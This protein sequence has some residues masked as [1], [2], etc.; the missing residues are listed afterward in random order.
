MTKLF[1]NGDSHT[2]RVWGDAGPTAGDILAEKFSCEIENLAMS[3]GSNQRIIRTTQ[4]RLK[5]LNPRSTLII[6]GW[7]SFERT[8]W[9]YGGRWHDICGDSA[10]AVDDDLKKR[11]KSH[12][13]TYQKWNDDTHE[14]WRRQQD[15]HHAIWV[16]HNLLHDLG[17]RFLFYQ[18][19]ETC[20]FDGCVEALLDFKLTWHDGTWAHDP[21]MDPSTQPWTGN[22]FSHWC[23]RQGFK[24][25]DARNH[26]GADAHRAWADYLAPLIAAKLSSLQ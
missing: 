13:E 12:V 1:I 23:R 14:Q 20:F 25:A 17:F 24:H 4:E 8:E 18:G 9:Y 16:F 2:A 10:Y 5:D 21:Y 22:S 15:Q 3:G 26:Y 6:I 7:S 11:W 19:C